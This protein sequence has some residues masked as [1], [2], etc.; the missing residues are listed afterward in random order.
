MSFSANFTPSSNTITAITQA[1]PGVVTTA[2]AHNY[3]TGSL[4]EI[5]MPLNVGMNQL[6]NAVV[7][8]TVVDST[9]FSIGIDTTSFDAFSISSTAQVPQVIP[10]GNISPGLIQSTDNAGNIIPEL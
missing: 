1:N 7:K 3:V 2:T 5:F 6:N 10:I 4:V 9:S 8:I